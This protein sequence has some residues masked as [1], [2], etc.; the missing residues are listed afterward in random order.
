MK[1]NRINLKNIRRWEL[2]EAYDCYR[3]YVSVDWEITIVWDD[4]G[5][6]V[7]RV[8]TFNGRYAADDAYDMWYDLLGE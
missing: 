5:G 7:Y 1:H 8:G 2:L 4:G 6:D 3:L